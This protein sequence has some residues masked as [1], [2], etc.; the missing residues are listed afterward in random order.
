LKETKVKTRNIELS[1]NKYAQN[2]ETSSDIVDFKILKS[3]TLIKTIHDEDFVEYNEALQAD[4]STEEKMIDYHLEFS[5]IHIIKL[6]E[7]QKSSY[8]LNY[9]IEFDYMNFNPH[10]IIKKESKI[11]RKDLKQTYLWLIQEINK[12]KAKNG[13]LINLFDKTYLAKIK[14]FTKIIHADKFKKNVKLPLI[15]TIEPDITQQGELI[16]HYKKNINQHG[17]AEVEANEMIAEFRK[18]K[19]GKNGLDAFGKVIGSEYKKSHKDLKYDTEDATINIKEDE[20]K[21]LYIA[22][23]KGYVNISKN[24]MYI[25]KKIKKR[26]INRVEDKVSEHEDNEIEV[27]ISEKDATQDSIGEGV[28][29]TSETIHVEGFVGSNS[30][31]HAT[32]LTIDGATHQSS[33]QNAKYAKINRHKGTIRAHQV[34]IN[35]LEGGTVYATNVNIDACLNGTVYGRDVSINNVK[36]NLKVYASHSISIGLVSGENNTFNIDYKKIPIL[37]KKIDFI[38][39]D[40]EDLKY[41]LQEAQRHNKAKVPEI[42]S[43][44]QKLKDEKNNILNSIN[45]AFI[46]IKKPFRG[47]NNI[48][49]T[50]D[51]IKELIYKTDS[52]KYE[53][54]YL[55]IKDEHITLKPVNISIDL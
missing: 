28:E 33:H 32:N 30:I 19:F 54:F 13:I 51:E 5:Q 34:D 4:Y 52:K 27:I 38:N 26:K 22:K 48:I 2:N 25:D 49:F 31:L 43:K 23:T 47:I 17:I 10:I 29:L 55:E 3:T 18:P 45:D 15:K 53:K 37:S 21:K 20:N 50:V 40:L 42:K 7:K 14:I 24:L 1:I 44:M 9:D 46:S 11:P 8:F 12:I 16:L 41:H 39:V 35:L 36:S 6:F